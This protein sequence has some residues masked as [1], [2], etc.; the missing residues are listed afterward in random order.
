MNISSS[1]SV[2][3][4]FKLAHRSTRSKSPAPPGNAI[5]VSSSAGHLRSAA[6]DTSSPGAHQRL[7]IQHHVNTLSDVPENE[8]NSISPPGSSGPASIKRFHSNYINAER[9]PH[10]LLSCLA[11]WLKWFCVFYGCSSILILSR[12]IV[13]RLQ[14]S[15]IDTAPHHTSRSYLSD[16]T[17]QELI[18]MACSGIYPPPRAFD[19]FALGS[20]LTVKKSRAYNTTA[21]L[22]LRDGELDLDALVVWASIWSGRNGFHALCF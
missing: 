17:N 14:Y 21:C 11:V 4:N 19:P 12:K 22:W 5:S 15:N 1:S 6:A 9:R 10:R 3:S 7:R 16:R 2:P 18:S 8:K 13:H 20:Q